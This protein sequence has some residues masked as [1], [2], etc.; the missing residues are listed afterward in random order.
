MSNFSF[1]AYF[2]QSPEFYEIHLYAKT[3]K[4]PYCCSLYGLLMKEF[5]LDRLATIRANEMECPYSFR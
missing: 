2:F 3:T 4:L 5:A 1:G